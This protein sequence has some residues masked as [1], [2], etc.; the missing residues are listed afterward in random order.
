MTYTKNGQ[1][2][3]MYARLQ[4]WLEDMGVPTEQREQYAKDIIEDVEE[5]ATNWHNEYARL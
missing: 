4:E 5:N 3:I 1:V 2:N